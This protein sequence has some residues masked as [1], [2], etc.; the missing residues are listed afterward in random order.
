[1]DTADAVS[2][3]SSIPQPQLSCINNLLQ[4]SVDPLKDGCTDT[5]RESQ[6]LS[7]GHSPSCSLPNQQP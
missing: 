3:P 4:K 6:G 2:L 5:K 1:M 7:F